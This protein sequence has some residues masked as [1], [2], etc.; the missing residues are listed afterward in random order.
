MILNYLCLFHT[1]NALND[2]ICSDINLNMQS[3]T[4]RRLLQRLAE[5]LGLLQH[6]VGQQWLLA[7]VPSASMLSSAV[8]CISV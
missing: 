5:R 8:K 1:T 2:D 6:D 7:P 3:K 4:I